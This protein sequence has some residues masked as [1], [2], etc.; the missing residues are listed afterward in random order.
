MPCLSGHCHKTQLNEKLDAKFMVCGYT[1]FFSALFSR[2]DNFR[3][4][5]FVY[6][7]DEVFPK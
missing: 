7:E 1:S 4:I 5:L 2:G 6:L 3:D